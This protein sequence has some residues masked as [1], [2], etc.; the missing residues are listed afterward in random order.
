[1]RKFLQKDIEEK[2]I[3]NIFKKVLLFSCFMLIVSLYKVGKQP[4]Y[5]H[6]FILSSVI[7]SVLTIKSV[8]KE[9]HAKTHLLCSEIMLSQCTLI[10]SFL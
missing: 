5:K 7:F 4:L 9:K 6:C 1:M 3:Q 2:N 8:R 10:L